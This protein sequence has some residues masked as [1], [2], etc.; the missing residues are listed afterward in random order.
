[1]SGKVDE[2]RKTK[3]SEKWVALMVIKDNIRRKRGM[4]FS[5]QMFL[6]FTFSLLFK[7]VLSVYIVWTSVNSICVYLWRK[8][9]QQQPKKKNKCDKSQKHKSK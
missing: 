5:E 9:Q 7:D 1:M 4:S 6:M 3:P 8:Q 2:Q